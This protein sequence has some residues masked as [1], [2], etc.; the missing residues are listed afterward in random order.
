MKIEEIATELARL[1]VE[2]E[3]A[4]LEH[5]KATEEAAMKQRRLSDLETEVS[6]MRLKL[7]HA[8]QLGD[9]ENA[10]LAHVT[11]YEGEYE[12]SCEL[13][14]DHTGH[15]FDGQSCYDDAGGEIHDCTLHGD[16]RV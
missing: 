11:W 9:T 13:P 3:H 5:Q 8:I 15:H 6:Q 14:E 10:C 2:R 4:A 12:G 1:F 16:F 7:N